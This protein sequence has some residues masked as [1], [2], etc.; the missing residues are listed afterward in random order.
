[1]AG[2]DGRTSARSGGNQ[3]EQTP[4]LQRYVREDRSRRKFEFELWK[5]VVTDGNIKAD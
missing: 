3:R 4:P 5:K 1:M 2:L